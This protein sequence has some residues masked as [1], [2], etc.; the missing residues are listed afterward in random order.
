[1][2]LCPGPFITDEGH[3]FIATVPTVCDVLHHV[4]FIIGKITG[5]RHIK[6]RNP[7]ARKEVIRLGAEYS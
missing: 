2:A 5:V 3:K 6:G 4:P 1:M 7:N